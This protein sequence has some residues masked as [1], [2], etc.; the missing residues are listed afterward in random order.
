[1]SRK[2]SLCAAVLLVFFA[3]SG[4]GAQAQAKPDPL[5]DSVGTILKSP[6]T[7]ASGYTRYNFP[8]RDI[9]LKL[10]DVSVAPGLAL[11][12]WAGFAGNADSAIAMGDLVLLGSE[13]AGVL[14]EL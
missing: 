9:P 14:R 7:A 3:L 6:P 8:R 12:S 11:G 10:G 13:V 4:A 5:W 1:M 2:P